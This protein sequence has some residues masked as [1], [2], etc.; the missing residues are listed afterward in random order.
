[1]SRPPELEQDESPGPFADRLID[2]LVDGALSES[3]RRALLQRLDAEPD[4]WRRCALAFLESQAWHQAL[5]P[6]AELGGPDSLTPSPLAGEGWGEGANRGPTGIPLTL[7]VPRK[8]GGDRSGRVGAWPRRIAIAAS[9][10]AA[11]ALGRAWRGEAVQVV[12]MPP[13]VK[14]E[15]APAPPPPELPRPAPVAA[16]PLASLEPVV[17][18][19]EQQGYRAERQ[20][21]NVSLELGDGRRLDVPVHEVR[22]RYIGDRTY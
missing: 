7:S 15:P 5:G 2:R 21:R 9:L 16:E 10:A 11:F 19:W 20:K 14:S 6:L 17:K 1:M 12:T 18:R 13:I 4:G 22:L 8:G 3:E